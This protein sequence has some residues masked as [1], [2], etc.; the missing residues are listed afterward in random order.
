MIKTNRNKSIPEIVRSSKAVVEHLFG[1]HEFCDEKRCRPKSNARLK[2]KEEGNQ[3]HYR[4]KK[5]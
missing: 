3:S 1:N 2:N 5:G 4:C